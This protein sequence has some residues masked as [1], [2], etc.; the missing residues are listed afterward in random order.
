[1]EDIVF[2]VGLNEVG[3]PA[4]TYLINGANVTVPQ[5]AKRMGIT[6]VAVRNRLRAGIPP[7]IALVKKVLPPEWSGKINEMRKRKRD[8]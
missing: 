4:K 1:M 6:V 7:E 3:R 2:P 8:Q 5:A